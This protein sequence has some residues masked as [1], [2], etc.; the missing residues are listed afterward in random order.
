M[1]PL[2]VRKERKRKSKPNPKTVDKIRKFRAGTN[3]M[4]D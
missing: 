1:I 4:E 2:T 3:E